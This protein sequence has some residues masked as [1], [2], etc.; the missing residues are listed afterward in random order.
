MSGEKYTFTVDVDTLNAIKKLRA[1]G[2]EARGV[3]DEN[4]KA[5]KKAKGAWETFQGTLGAQAVVGAFKTIANAATGAFG[6][7]L[8]AT[9]TTERIKTELATMT[10]SVGA[11]VL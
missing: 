2:E 6:S 8:E 3:G 4:D 7:I 10:G 5:A 9:K 11:R 1:V